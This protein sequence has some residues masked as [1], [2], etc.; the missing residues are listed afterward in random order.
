MV[1]SAGRVIKFATQN[2]FRNA[3]LTAA[4]VSVLALTLV[5][6]N[7]LVALNVLGKIAVSAVESRIDVSVHFKPEVEESRVQTVKTALLSMAEV[8]EV[9]YFSPAEALAR[10]SQDYIKDEQVLRS[11]G[12][13][14]ENPFGATLVIRARSL[15]GYPKILASLNDPSFSSLIDGKDFDDR[16]AVIDRVKRVS[17]NL[18]YFL[19]A[20]SGVFGFI[21]LLIVWNA[22]RVSV[23]TRREEIGIMRLVGASNGFIRGP[24]YIETMFWSVL[25]F[26]IALG[27]FLPA[28]AVA[29]PYIARFFGS[30]Q[31]DVLGFYRANL[32]TLVAG[33]LIG[34][35]G[36]A[37][38]TTLM[39]TRRYLKV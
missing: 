17:V 38:L 15:D 37:A 27:V 8:K 29:Q 31:V 39:A 21:T 36:M 4:T 32:A 26:A 33:Q 3:W 13:V 12:E 35:A 14:G 1:V 22:I 34:V 23:Y 24:F 10:F 20:V 30:T 25:A 2:F 16:Q 11:L 9:Q 7:V 28:M 5:S 6:V 18:Q 19:L